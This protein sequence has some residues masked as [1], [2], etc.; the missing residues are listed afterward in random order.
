MITD[1]TTLFARAHLK[2]ELVSIAALGG[3]QIEI[4]EMT[5]GTR[6]KLSQ[7]VSDGRFADVAALVASECVPILKG[8]S[9]DEISTSMAPSVLEE[10]SAAAMKLSGLTEDSEKN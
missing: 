2:R 5:L 3:E 8:T 4:V 10:I 1:K 7:L 6:G 9:A